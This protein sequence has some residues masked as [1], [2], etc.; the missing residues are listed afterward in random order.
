[1]TASLFIPAGLCITKMRKFLEDPHLSAHRPRGIEQGLALAEL[2]EQGEP[3][4]GFDAMGRDRLR[5]GP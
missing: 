3:E 2:T 1:M 5:A 4:Q